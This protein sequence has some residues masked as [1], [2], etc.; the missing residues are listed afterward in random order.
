MRGRKPKPTAL[1]VLFGNP[2][3]RPLNEHE[4]EHPTIDPTLPTELVE[5]AARD[6][7]LRIVPTLTRGHCTTV[8]RAVLLGYCL[9]F[10]QWQ[11]LEVEAA[12][13]PFVVK[14]ASG[15]PIPNP[16]LTM[17][18]R[19]FAL[20]LKAASELGITPSSRSRILA[21]PTPDPTGG[22]D[23]FSRFQRRRRRGRL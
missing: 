17:A 19:A 1:K 9:K 16:A 7:W 23:E 18:N 6:E 2:G 13:H 5:P 15:S 3:R 10:G 20:V 14:S 12:K 22:D 21:I 11:A 4:P 8:D